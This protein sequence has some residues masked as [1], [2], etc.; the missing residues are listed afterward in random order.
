MS[1]LAHANAD[2]L[3]TPNVSGGSRGFIKK[4]ILAYHKEV[5]KKDGVTPAEGVR[6]ITISLLAHPFPKPQAC[7]F[8]Q[9]VAAAGA[10]PMYRPRSFVC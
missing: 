4:V 5:A 9:A 3:V 10:V 6:G 1:H 7:W 8:S 2:Q